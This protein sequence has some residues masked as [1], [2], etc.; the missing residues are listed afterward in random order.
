MNR[1]TI[2]CSNCHRPSKPYSNSRIWSVLLERTRMKA[3]KR[4]GNQKQTPKMPSN[5]HAGT[6][7]N[8]THKKQTPKMKIQGNR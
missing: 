8:S 6:E 4:K 2:R 1:S 3:Q 5:L 7:F